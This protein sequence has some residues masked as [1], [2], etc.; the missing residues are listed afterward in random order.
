MDNS[1][2]LSVLAMQIPPGSD[3]RLDYMSPAV[4]YP[5]RPMSEN[6]FLD[7]ASDGR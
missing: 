5:F 3:F 7:M 4:R 6:F 1:S 2:G